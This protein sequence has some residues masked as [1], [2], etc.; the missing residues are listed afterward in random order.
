MAIQNG[1]TTAPSYVNKLP[2]GAQYS[3]LPLLTVGDEVPLLQG[4]FGSFTTSTT[5]KYASTGIPDGLGIYETATGY[6][7]FVNHELGDTSKSDF[8]TTVTGQITGARVSLFQFDKNWKVIGGKNLIEKAVDSK[9]TELGKIT[10]TT[11]AATGDIVS[12]NSTLPAFGRFC[13]SFLAQN[14]FEGGPVYFAPEESGSAS[15][16][17]AVTTDGTAQAIDGLGRF[18]KENIVS[19]SQYRAT[20]SDKTVLLVNEDNADGEL[21]MFVGKQTVAD[22]NGFKDGDLYVLKVTGYSNETLA[23]GVKVGATWTKVDRSAVYD[24]NGNPLTTGD[25]LSAWVNGKDANGNDR[26]T[27]FRRLEDLAEDPNNPGTFYVVTTGAT[28]KVDGTTATVAADAENPYAKLYRFS[29]NAADPTASV[30]NFELVLTGGPNTGVSYD[31]I[32]VDKNGKIAILEDTTAFGKNVLVDQNRN[33][34]VWSYDIATDSV[35]PLFEINQ[36]AAGSVFNRPLSNAIGSTTPTPNGEWETSGIVDLPQNGLPGVSGVANDNN[37]PFSVGRPPAIDNNEIIQLKLEKPLNLASGLGQ[38]KAEE[39]KFASTGSDN[40]TVASSQTLFTG[41]GAD[42][43]D[44]TQSNTTIN[45]GNGDDTVFVASDSSVFGGEGNDTAIIGANGPAGNTNVDGGNGNDS[46][47]V[48]EAKPSNN[49][50]GAA[51]DDNLQVVEGSVQML[52]GGSGKD[53]LRS[54][55]NNN[56]LYGGSGDDKLYSNTND[57]LSG[58]DGDDVLFAGAGGGNRLT[59]GAGADQFWIANASLPTSKNIVTD[60]TAGL[61]LIGIGGIA[62]AT[63]FSDLTLVQQGSD[64]LVKAGATELVSLLGITST[65]LTANNFTFA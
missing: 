2:D 4:N 47:T 36:N 61:D 14:G 35:K 23:E 51:G 28:N 38:P 50:F 17:W 39:I 31:N 32:V 24:A 20:N 8:S 12:L 19:A 26:S 21:Y 7:V 40:I 55:G 44:S 49:L 53:S 46:L 62:T 15:R 29:L 65:I 9:G 18:A 1:R 10:F 33:G 13:S 11:D 43:V 60:F 6:Y 5:E 27:N 57:F 54:G 63:K 25:A 56:R 37:Y 16:G 22:P 41:D 42:T 52:F 59:G 45:V 48:V 34:R 58:G 64:T 3:L 30:N